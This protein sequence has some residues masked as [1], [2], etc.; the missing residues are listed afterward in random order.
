MFAIYFFTITFVALYA[1]LKYIFTYWERRDFPYLEPTFVFGNM[2]SFV[3]RKRSFGLA[4]WDLYRKTTKPVV[5]VYMLTNPGVLVRDLELVKKVLVT[6]FDHFYDRGMY[7]NKKRE[8]IASFLAAERGEDW[9]TLRQKLSPLFSSG[10]LRLMFPT[11]LQQVK[12]LEEHLKPMAE[13]NEIVGMKDI[14][15]RYALDVVGSIFFG[16]DVNTMQNPDQDFYRMN[17]ILNSPDFKENLRMGLVFIA[18]KIIDFL[19]MSPFNPEAKRFFLELTTATI[20]HREENKVDRNDFMKLMLELRES[21]KGTTHQLSIEEIASNCLL[22]YN[23]GT[24]TTSGTV[25]FLLY[26]LALNPQVMQTLLHE[27]DETLAK[28]NEISYDMIQD[29]TY[30]D[31]CLKETLRKYPGL[32]SLNR[33]CTKDYRIPGTKFTI[34]KGMSTIISVMGLH[35][36]SRYF[37]NPEVFDPERFRKGNET[38][39]KDAYMPFGDG[40]RQCIA[41]RLGFIEAKLAAVMLLSKYK[42]ETIHQKPMEFDGYALTLQAKDGL[43]LKISLRH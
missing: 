14:L 3:L 13:R 27:I 12:R 6:D 19:R 35:Y 21:E 28:S 5:G 15:I 17:K 8:P 18:P 4:I 41:V 42:F 22:F 20:K 2:K 32:A 39:N 40:P 11:I 24:E 33:E 43:P 23:A 9:K 36:D 7:N 1:L 38:Y 10:K 31:M 34:K 29:M 37:P 16:T 30:L 26:E 25:G